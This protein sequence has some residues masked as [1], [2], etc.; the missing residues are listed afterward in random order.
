MPSKSYP[1]EATS[2]YHLQDHAYGPPRL[3]DSEAPSWVD[4]LPHDFK[5][6]GPQTPDRD[7][8]DGAPASSQPDLSLTWDGHDESHNHHIWRFDGRRRHH[9]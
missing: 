8:P 9:H 3:G 4:G 7:A 5:G 2:P 6:W 1:A